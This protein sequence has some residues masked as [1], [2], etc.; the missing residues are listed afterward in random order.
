L[1]VVGCGGLILWGGVQHS[2]TA[3][4]LKGFERFLP[5][6]SAELS[7]AVQVCDATVLNSNTNAWLIRKHH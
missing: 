6:S 7:N 5:Y 3:L 2:M 1:L 4:H